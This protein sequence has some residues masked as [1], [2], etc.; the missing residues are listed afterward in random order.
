[1]LDKFKFLLSEAKSDGDKVRT[2]LYSYLLGQLQNEV[3]RGR[4]ATAEYLD[5]VVR[6]VINGIDQSLANLKADDERIVSLLKEK[7]LLLVHKLPDV[8]TLTDEEEKEAIAKIHAELG[9]TTLSEFMRKLRE[10]Y[11]QERLNGKATVERVNTFLRSL[12]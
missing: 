8:V 4:A 1:M 6:E 7:E 12:K 2:N 9:C 3:G 10:L 11:T 5:K